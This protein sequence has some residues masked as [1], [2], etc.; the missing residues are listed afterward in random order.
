[1]ENADRETSREKAVVIM[2]SYKR[3]MKS[4]VLAVMLILMTAVAMLPVISSGTPFEASAASVTAS[5]KVS[6]DNVNLRKS[7]SVSSKVVTTLSKNTALTIQTEIFTVKNSSAAENRWYYVTAG[8]KS[9][10]IRAD[11]VKDISYGKTAAS[12]TDNL[13][14]R[15]GPSSAFKKLGTVNA[16][17]PLTLQL[18]AKFKGSNETWYRATVKNTTAYVCGNYVRMGKSPLIIKSEEELEGKSELAKALLSN[19]TIGGR[20]RYVYTFNTSNC[21]K[22]F[23]VE[24][25]KNAKVPQGFTFTGN[26]YYILYGMAAGQSI[27]TYSA[28]GK[29]LKASKF[30]F[31]IGHP[32]GITWDPVTK[33]CYIFKGNQKRIYTWDP[34]TNKFGK[35]KTPY[36]SSGVA[37]DNSTNQIYATSRTGIRVYS[38]DGSFKHQRLF[39]RC[40]H[41]IYY[42]PQ[43]C[44][45]AEGFI[46]HGISGSNKKKTNF[47]DIYRASDSA[48]LGS[49]KITIG[50]IESAAVGP[51]GYL[52]LLINTSGNK[53]YIWKT[54][55]NINEL[56]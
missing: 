9:G 16:G 40:N 12:A 25:Y 45:A 39:S 22:L 14:Y 17:T 50:E 5:G 43:D 7:A 6:E 56:K 35:S 46:F 2:K 54:P 10:Y 48:Y 27:V 34:A 8:K 30:S 52:V 49:I 19:P 13:N 53:D 23:A 21:K 51:D 32:N 3:S 20:A 37:Y 26:E 42:Y 47:L 44:G 55:L 33:K 29:R 1:M 38:A 31:C 36:S 18:P 28:D 11:L 41:G 15:N 4:R 24:G